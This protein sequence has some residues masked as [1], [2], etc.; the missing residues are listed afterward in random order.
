MQQDLGWDFKGIRTKLQPV[1]AMEKKLAGD[2]SRTIT[3][4]C[5]SGQSTLMNLFPR[6]QMLEQ[7]YMFGMRV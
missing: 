5:A 3:R 2:Q 1:A 6:M 7:Y 4:N